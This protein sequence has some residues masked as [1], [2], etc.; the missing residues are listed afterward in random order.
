[1]L[2]FF[3]LPTVRRA[4]GLRAVH[5]IDEAHSAILLPAHPHTSAEL[6]ER[7]AAFLDASHERMTSESDQIGQNIASTVAA[8][9]VTTFPN[10]KPSCHLCRLGD[11][12]F[13]AIHESEEARM[14]VLARGS[15][16]GQTPWLHSNIPYEIPVRWRY[17]ELAGEGIYRIRLFSDGAHLQYDPEKQEASERHAEEEVMYASAG[18]DIHA[19]AA[20]MGTWESRA[21]NRWVGMDDLSVAGFDV[22]VLPRHR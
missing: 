3:W 5:I 14:T 16:Y 8:A 4:S 9:L 2:I 12:G 6:K 20:E 15:D 17:I 19:L 10:E 1:M 22:Y 21:D 7:F 13:V 18:K 11:S